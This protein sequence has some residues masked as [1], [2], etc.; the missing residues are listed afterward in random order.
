MSKLLFLELLVDPRLHLSACPPK[1]RKSV[2]RRSLS[3]LHLASSLPLDQL[4]QADTQILRL[5][6]VEDCGV[7]GWIDRDQLLSVGSDR[8]GKG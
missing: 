5:R 3:H 2:P 8:V 6:K 1:T 4:D 7:L